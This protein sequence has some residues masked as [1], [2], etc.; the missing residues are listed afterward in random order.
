MGVSLKVGLYTVIGFC[1]LVLL[2]FGAFAQ[3]FY[4]GK[5]IT[6]IQGREPGGTG[7][8][9]ARAITKFLQKYIPGNPT[10]IHEFMGGGGGLRAANHI[11]S[12]VRPDGL[13]IGCVSSG[14]LSAALL[15]NPGVKYQLEKFHY[16]GAA[17][18]GGH[19][20]FYTRKEAGI[21]NLE[22]LRAASGLRI[23]AQSVGHSNYNI[24]RLLAYLL[25][26]KDARFVTGYSS[27]E[28]DAALLRGEVDARFNQSHSVLRQ[29]PEWLEKGLMDFHVVLEIPKGEKNPK[30]AHLPE[31]ETFARN[32]KER[33]LIALVRAFRIVGSPFILPPATPPDRVQI[34]QQA[35]TKAFKDPEFPKEFE[36]MVGDE[37]E[38]VFPEVMDKTIKELPRSPEI[39]ALMKKLAGPEALPAR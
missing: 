28:I 30:F 34:L 19:Y 13:T 4:Q 15:G 6:V 17:D 9:R 18:A 27:P 24:A 25:P 11:Y 20:V 12:G 36:K 8:L 29:H 7:D 38:I 37:A 22:K 10:I 32:D 26:L 16:L 31:I 21:A 2:P 35:M 5:T 1:A 33:E 14:L 23:G 39:I 3:P